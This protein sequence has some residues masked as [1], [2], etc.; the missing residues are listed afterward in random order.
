MLYSA[1][2]YG[3]NTVQVDMWKTL[4]TLTH[5]SVFWEK[6]VQLANTTNIGLTHGI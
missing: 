5:C 3:E 1:I 6:S 4:I 2:R